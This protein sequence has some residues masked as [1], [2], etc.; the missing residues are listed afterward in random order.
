MWAFRS[1]R[2]GVL[3][4][5]YFPMFLKEND[6]VLFYGDSITDCGRNRESTGDDR[7]GGGYVN[8]CHSLLQARFP[9]LKL[10]VSNKGV[11]G[12]RIYDLEKRLSEDVLV[13]KPTVISFLIG[14]NDT[15]RRYDGHQVSAIPEFADSF[16]R[17][18][19]TLKKELRTRFVVCEPF[20]LPVPEDR[21]KWREDLDP[22]IQAIRALAV[23]F[24]ALYL[25]LD[26]LFAQAATRRPMDFWLPDGVHP[27][28][29]GHGL[30]A[31]AWVNLIT[32]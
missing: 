5:F 9:D 30:I 6:H 19:F 25:P 23:E 3:C 15:W 21:V 24:G 4:H 27:S 31:D 20:L 11:S 29:A 1:R 18:L 8:L 12:N 17:I 32:R 2:G 22:R 10:T 13:L 7:L 26:G 14:I 16:R 28:A